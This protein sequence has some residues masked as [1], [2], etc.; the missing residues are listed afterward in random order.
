MKQSI[1]L[2]FAICS[3]MASAQE[4]PADVFRQH[5]IMVAEN[6][7]ILKR[8]KVAD[9]QGNP[10]FYI[11]LGNYGVYH[12]AEPVPNKNGELF[13]WNQGAIFFY[14]IEY[15]LELLTVEEME[16]GMVFYRFNYFNG[17]KKFFIEVKFGNR[18]DRWELV[19]VA[20]T[21]VKGAY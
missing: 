1:F 19:D 17:K 7:D 14:N 18:Y 11:N 21:K 5:M 20:I 16:D 15:A 2:V 8:Y 9:E 12:Q 13:L 4:I 6:Q 10:L 3:A